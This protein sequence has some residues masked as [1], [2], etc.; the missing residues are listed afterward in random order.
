[1]ASVSRGSAAGGSTPQPGEDRR[2][3]QKITEAFAEAKAH[4][5]GAAC[6]H[7]AVLHEN[8]VDFLVEN[9]QLEC[10]VGKEV[11]FLLSVSSL[12]ALVLRRA[13]TNG[14]VLIGCLVS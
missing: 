12:L 14:V 5:H 4:V 8:H 7:V 9:G 1:M 6:G 2:Q 3:E 11:R 10:F 13:V